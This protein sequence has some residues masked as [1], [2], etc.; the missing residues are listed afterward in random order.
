MGYAHGQ[1][2]RGCPP[3]S[4]LHSPVSLLALRSIELPRLL[5]SAP[6]PLRAS[7][8]QEY[9]D[10]ASLRT[11]ANAVWREPVL[12]DCWAPLRRPGAR[13]TKDALLHYVGRH[14]QAIPPGSPPIPVHSAFGGLAIAKLALCRGCA[15]ASRGGVSEHVAFCRDFGR[16]REGGAARRILVAPKLRVQAQRLALPLTL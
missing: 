14:Q 4:P 13:F 3:A 8:A 15:Y 1:H 6:E 16:G 7:P 2:I 10:I 5:R 12:T 11:D 9:H